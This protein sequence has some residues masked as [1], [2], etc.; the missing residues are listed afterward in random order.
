MTDIVT[1]LRAA[2]K[3]KDNMPRMKSETMLT[4]GLGLEAADEIERLKALLAE[5]ADYLAIQVGEDHPGRE[6]Y[7]DI[8][9][10]YKR[11]MDLVNRI[12]EALGG[13]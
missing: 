9:R 1:R 2:A 10:R 7:P 4:V 8:M 13:D 5:A 11:D 6:I 12:R 3:D